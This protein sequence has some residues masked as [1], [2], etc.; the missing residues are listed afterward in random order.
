MFLSHP[1]SVVFLY[2]LRSETLAQL[3]R[4]S[5][6]P[7][8]GEIGQW[9]WGLIFG[10]PTIV[11]ILNES[12]ERLQRRKIPLTDALCFLRNLTLPLWVGMLILERVL[13]LNGETVPMHAFQ[14]L[15]WSATVYNLLLLVNTT[16][17]TRKRKWKIRVPNLY[18]LAVRILVVGAGLG[19]ILA[20]IWQVDLANIAS[21]L[22]VGSLVIALALQ[23]TLSNLVS[24]FLLLLDR[25]FEEGDWIQIGDLDAEVLE[26]NWRSVRLKNRDRD[27]ITIPNG[28]LGRAT[29]C[30]FTAV[31]VLHAEHIYVGFSY[32]DPPN[33][34]KQVLIQ[35]AT[36][37]TGIVSPPTPSVRVLSYGDSA[38]QY[39]V[40]FFLDDYR[41][42]DEICSEL[43]SLIFYRAKR[44]NLTMPYPISME[45]Q[46][47]TSP[48]ALPDAEPVIVSVLKRFPYF[49]SL[50]SAALQT[51]AQEAALESYGV[52]ECLVSVGE[53]DQAFFIIEQGRVALTTT[54]H[55]ADVQ[56]VTQLVQGDCFGELVLLRVEPSQVTIDVIEDL[57]V[58]RI[59]PALMATVMEKN[60]R[61][62]REINRLIEDRKKMIRLAKTVAAPSQ[63]G[64][65]NGYFPVLEE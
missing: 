54:D 6:N 39:E 15:L 43:R 1:M 27:I 48:M 62:A 2:G 17:S 30:N 34:V 52:G 61:L 56:E 10:T 51:L 4:Y 58:V 3:W 50:D 60:P 65:L 9:G 21:A 25:P 45:Y 22:G 38:L 5:S 23:D 47:T 14:T 13:S 31:D 29:I 46:L 18:L 55:N 49:S 11:I 33:V 41:H 8:G 24:G 7:F 37:T 12:I 16:L 35:A 28:E 20:A 53:F 19:Y 44:H 26:M 32:D 63:Q 36:A 59:A 57:N 64:Y 42:K 40:K